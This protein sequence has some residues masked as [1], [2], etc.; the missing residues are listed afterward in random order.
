[1]RYTGIK[2]NN[3]LKKVTILF[4]T[5]AM[6]FMTGC[7]NHSQQTMVNVESGES[8]QET[9]K[10]EDGDLETEESKAVDKAGLAMAIVG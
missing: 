1:M 4:V 6:Y 3:S 5:G 8:V 9:L 2:K 10:T 7:G